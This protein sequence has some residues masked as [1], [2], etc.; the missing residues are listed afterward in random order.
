MINEIYLLSEALK[1]ANISP[2]AWHSRYGEISGIKDSAPCVRIVLDGESV[3]MVESLNPEKGKHIRRY[4][5]NQ[6]SFPAMNLAALYRVTDE[7][8]KAEI[9][10]LLKTE[11]E[12]LNIERVRS[13]CTDSNWTPKFIK[14]Y[15]RNFQDRPNELH[16]KLQGEFAFNPLN[17][18][19]EASKRFSDPAIM[20]QALSELAFNMLSN[21]TDIRLAL[22]LLFYMPQSKKSGDTEKDDSGKLSV[23]L[24]T[25][26]LEDEGYSAAGA[27]FTN[28][29]NN[30]LLRADKKANGQETSSLD[31]FGEP[32]APINEPMPQVKL[33]AGFTVSLRTMFR[34]QPCQFRYGKIENDS[35]PI[36]K[37]KRTAVSAAL[38]WVSDES[39]KN[40]TWTLLD[41]NE[42]M[43]VFPSKFSDEELQSFTD[44]FG[45]EWNSDEEPPLFESKAK[46]FI[47]YINMLRLK[48]P[49][50]APEWIQFFVVL[51]LDKSSTRGKV[52]Y[53]YNADPETIIQKSEDWKKA[54][55]NLPPFYFGKPLTPFPLGIAEIQ[56]RIWQQDGTVAKGENKAYPL[57]Y[58]MRMFFGLP[59]DVLQ[60]D[61]QILMK[62]TRGL[63]VY[64]GPRLNTHRE[65]TKKALYGLRATLSLTGMLLYWTDHRK[66]SYMNEYPY[67]LGQLLKAAD[68]LHELYCAAVRNNQNPQ[69]FVGGS[70]YV[71]ASEF[72]G[73]TVA[74][75]AQ[76]M[77]PYLNWAKTN[78][79]AKVSHKN[80]KGEDV[81]GL[82]AGYY[83]YQFNKIADKLA[84]QITEQTRFSDAEKA[85]LFIGYLASFPKDN[86]TDP[87]DPE[88]DNVDNVK[89]ENNNG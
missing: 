23:I 84:G 44:M 48:D 87:A 33:D 8:V 69:Q 59:K 20:H 36:A 60:H 26:D 89:G 22:Q 12:N 70:M 30:A 74:Q 4:G 80:E 85:K 56:K 53:S 37:E 10:R 34:G 5:D 21:K 32:Y 24:D 62:N 11:G 18:L 78:R 1:G 3:A 61:L 45:D 2:D 54:A 49:E 14:K 79:N 83:L 88:A 41:K 57:Y 73:R 27:R 16:E 65:I 17:E 40:K 75:L 6:G 77:M 82:S 15:H 31:A 52:V 67:L 72:P 43:F 50:N 51:K 38:K 42:V 58:G 29:L 66:E 81:S 7:S 68:G 46:L 35:Y 64:A 76:R 13:W 71:S 28:G 63:A 25:F 39:M 9:T 47:E 55:D 19:I 86:P